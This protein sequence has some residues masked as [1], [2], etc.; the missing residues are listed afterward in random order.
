[1]KYIRFGEIPAEEKSFIYRN[2]VPIGREK[3]ISVYF[4]K[5]IKGLW[6]A[7]MPNTFKFGQGNTYESLIDDVLHRS[8]DVKD[9]RKTYLVKG[10]FI[11]YGSDGEPL[12]KNARILKRIA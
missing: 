3:G 7:C 1:M 12:I 10:K 8:K 6:H 4:G 5:K 2:S 9:Q 11:G